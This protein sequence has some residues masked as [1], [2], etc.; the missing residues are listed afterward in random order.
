MEPKEDSIKMLEMRIRHQMNLSA[1]KNM[2]PENMKYY[3]P[4]SGMIRNEEQQSDGKGNLQQAAFMAGSENPQQPVPM[5]GRENPQQ[6]APIGGD[7][8]DGQM[9][10]ENLP[11]DTEYIE[12]SD[13][14]SQMIES[15]DLSETKEAQHARAKNGYERVSRLLDDEEGSKIKENHLLD[16][17]G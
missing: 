16:A 1:E 4:P 13:E 7:E 6:A 3:V 2:K 9:L 10:Y 17:K 8:T 12:R 15:I 11:A 14:M 5:V